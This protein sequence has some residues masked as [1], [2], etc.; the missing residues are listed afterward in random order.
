MENEKEHMFTNVCSFDKI[1]LS[2]HKQIYL[3]DDEFF[4]VS[5]PKNSKNINYCEGEKGMYSVI[6][7]EN[8]EHKLKILSDA[9]KY[10]VSCSS[11]GSMRKNKKGGLGNTSFSGICHSWSED[12]RCISLLK[13]L[14]TNHCMFDCA[15]CIN[16]RSNDIERTM[17]S[18]EEIVSLTINFYKRN[19]IEGLFLSSGVYKSPD[20][21]MDLLYQVAWKL[22]VEENFNGYIHMKAIPGASAEMI[23][24]V[25][26]LVDRMSVNIEMPSEKSLLL[27]APQKKKQAIFIPMKNIHEKIKENKEDSKKFRFSSAY[28]PAGQTTQMIVGATGETDRQIVKLSEGLYKK[29]ELKRVYY[30]AFVPVSNNPYLPALQE[31]PLKREHRLYQADWLLR[32]YGFTAEEILTEENPYFDVEIDPKSNWALQNIDKFPIEIN[33]CEYEMLLRIPGIGVRSAHK[34]WFARK[35]GN[36]EFHHL[37][38][39]GIVLKRAKYFIT[40]NGRFC[41]DYAMNMEFIREKMISQKEKNVQVNQL[42]FLDSQGKLIDRVI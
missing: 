38:S 23:D 13:I 8:I 24:K 41:G 42:S 36:I 11:S 22:R 17:L 28:V 20:N 2:S 27:L 5:F 37:K 21:T 10:D 15:Y 39:F 35:Y 14:V 25:G 26:A 9:A 40:C 33:S 16:R 31:P 32:Y 29:M 3:R 12:G 18:P 1:Y 19:Y 34:I 30:S 6:P 4:V 7:F